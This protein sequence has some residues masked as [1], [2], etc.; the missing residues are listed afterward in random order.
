MTTRHTYAPQSQHRR[1]RIKLLWL[2]ILDRYKPPVHNHVF[3]ANAKNKPRSYGDCLILYCPCGAGR[4]FA[5]GKAAI[6]TGGAR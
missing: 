4:I 1:F 5:T 6:Q 3:E 2:W